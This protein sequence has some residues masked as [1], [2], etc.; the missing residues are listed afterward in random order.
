M[1]NEETDADTDFLFSLAFNE[2]FDQLARHLLQN[3]THAVRERAAE[4]LAEYSGSIADERVDRIKSAL[5]TSVQQEPAD[6]VRA[7]TIAA[8]R[9]LDPSALDD[10]VT[11]LA[12]RKTPTPGDAPHPTFLLQWLDS[13]HPELRLV[14]VVGLADLDNPRVV[15][16][17][18]TA[19]ADPD[20]RVQRRAIEACGRVGDD[21]CVRAVARHLTSD[22]EAFQHAAAHALQQIGTDRAIRALLPLAKRG[23]GELRRTAIRS[24]GGLGSLNVLGML[25]RA[26]DEAEPAIRAAA[27]R[28]IIELVAAA[29]GEQSHTVRETVAKQ[30]N[31]FP[32]RDVVPEFLTL[33]TDTDHPEVRRNTAWLLGRIADDDPRQDVVRALIR[34]LTDADK[35]AA[36]VAASSLVRIN[37]PTVIEELEKYLRANDL[38]SNAL[39]RADFVRT[40]I[41]DSEAEQRLKDAV[42]FTKV[43]DPGD[44]TRK[45][46]NSE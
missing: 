19:C 40:Q 6:D 17:L 4:L 23:E 3:T 26:L 14:A 38:D 9:E 10:L 36:Q 22:D 20:P 13:D 31:T 18:A 37:D 29:S 25:L 27:T 15:P 5:I 21:R 43:S 1:A 46:A 35:Q 33:F 11:A 24:L 30:L 32:E 42:E 8:L 41:T 44:Y 16:K 39:S 12:D 28:S 2:Q 45:K 7:W 34:E